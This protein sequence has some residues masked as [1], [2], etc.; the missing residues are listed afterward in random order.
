[1]LT[2]TK[3]GWERQ[4]QATAGKGYSPEGEMD[5]YGSDLNYGEEPRGGPGILD[6]LQGIK[7]PR[8]KQGGQRL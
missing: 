5:G 7:L 2:R 3:D 4:L 1:M 6:R 8:P